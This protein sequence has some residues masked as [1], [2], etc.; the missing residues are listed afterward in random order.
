MLPTPQDIRDPFTPSDLM[1]NVASK[2]S[3]ISANGFMRSP[4]DSVI[5]RMRLRGFID[6][7][8]KEPIALLEVAGARTYLVREGDDININPSLPNSVIRITK[9]TRNSIT[10]ETGSILGSIRVQR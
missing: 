4:I 5:P 9:I 10:V 8:K 2:T 3:G 1:F 7:D 6:Q